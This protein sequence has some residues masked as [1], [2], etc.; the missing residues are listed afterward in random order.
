[1]SDRWG[2]CRWCGREEPV[3]DEGLLVIHRNND[4]KRAR[5]TWCLGG[6]EAPTVPPGPDVLPE[7]LPLPE[8][9]EAPAASTN[10][11]AVSRLNLTSS[12]EDDHHRQEEFD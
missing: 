10:A 1:V 6:R 5:S 11:S 9:E 12:F 8:P 2:Y 7:D 4:F 3:T